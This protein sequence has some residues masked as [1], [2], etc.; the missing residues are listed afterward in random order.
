MRFRS[1]P[2][3]R[4]MLAGSAAVAATLAGGVPFAAR[5]ASG[6]GIHK[7]TLGALQITI[8]S[9]GVLNIPT[10]LLNRNKAPAAIEAALDG[11]LS[12]PGQVQY[13]VNIVL[14]RSGADLVLIDAGA[15]GTW[16]P[17]AGKLADRLTAAGVDP[18]SITKVVITHGHPDHLWGL[19]DEFD[20]TPRFG[21]AQHIMPAPELDYWR[22]VSVETLP[23]R[24]QGVAAGA[25][26]V[27]GT[28]DGRLAAAAPN[29]EI[30]S[31]IAYVPTPGHTPGHC[32]VRISSGSNGLIV[33]ADTLFHPHVSFAH[34]DWQP[35]ADMDGAAAVASRRRLL[36]MAAT[37]GLQLAAYHIPFPGLGRVERHG[38]AYRWVS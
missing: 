4:A 6:T 32:S 16:E 12:A 28:V 38:S 34:P 24:M 2:T 36:D 27:I 13:G 30:A 29:A 7:L 14:V 37:D 15:G 33:T 18:D 35:V 9:D 22:K 8:L 10:R 21:K 17:T 19:V 20:D 23:E 31:G 26:R 5:A 3:R 25:K 11:E 1:H